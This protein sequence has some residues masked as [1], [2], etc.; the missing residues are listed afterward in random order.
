MLN[1]G[2]SR[3]AEQWGVKGVRGAEMDQIPKSVL[4]NGV[5]ETKMDQIP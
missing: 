5:R 3:G 4:K 1:N 2:G